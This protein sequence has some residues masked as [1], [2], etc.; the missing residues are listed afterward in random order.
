M[1]ISIDFEGTYT[2]HR[3]FF[4]EF[5]KAMQN[6]GHKIGII[7][8]ERDKKKEAIKEELGFEPDFMYL[9]GETETIANA[10]LWKA[11]KMDME[12]VYLHF[13]DDASEIKKYTGRWTVKTLNSSEPSKY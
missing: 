1:K 10:N 7:T 13:D 3:A 8:G 6:E 5:A 4:N 12:D 2:E 9:W 11:Q